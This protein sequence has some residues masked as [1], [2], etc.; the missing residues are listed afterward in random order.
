MF[1]KA[2]TVGLL[3]ALGEVINGNV[4]VRVLSRL[5]GKRRA[6][7][8]SFFS[9]VAIIYTISWFAL[10][11]V[12]PGNYLNSYTVGF[13]WLLI[14]LCL[15]LYFGRYVFKFKWTKIAEDFNPL[16]GNLLSLGMV[17]LFFSPALV[18]W[19]QQ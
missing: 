9:G 2:L 1:L 10:P 17:F 16:K 3:L 19:L 4:R 11:W 7:I 12:A 8:I 15:D 14:L 18:F 5:Y 13:I 6:K